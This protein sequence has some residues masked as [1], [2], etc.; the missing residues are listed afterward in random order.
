MIRHSRGPSALQLSPKRKEEPPK[1]RG[2]AAT[3][4]TTGEAL[5]RELKAETRA[6]QTSTPWSARLRCLAVVRSMRTSREDSRR[7]HEERNAPP[8][9]APSLRCAP[10]LR[11][12]GGHQTLG[13]GRA[14]GDRD[15]I[16]RTRRMISLGDGDLREGFWG[17]AGASTRAAGHRT[18][19][20]PLA[21]T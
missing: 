12:I 19:S 8:P 1:Q 4:P 17:G 9:S 7:T 21:R 14:R 3:H 15:S 20:C 11:C 5:L 18:T 13:L 16:A 6:G 2:A 10:Q